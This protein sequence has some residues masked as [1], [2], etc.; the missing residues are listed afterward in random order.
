MSIRNWDAYYCNQHLTKEM[1][2]KVF[3]RNIPSESLQPNL[4]ARS[5][6]TS[7]TMPIVDCRNKPKVPIVKYKDYSQ[8]KQ[9]NPGYRGPYNGYSNNVDVES[10]LF[11][12]FRV[13]QKGSDQMKYII[14]QKIEVLKSI[15]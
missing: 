14:N 6:S 2:E 12:K 9:F 13:L 11:N 4:N 10:R 7:F 5:V 3:K 8:H 1:S 15:N